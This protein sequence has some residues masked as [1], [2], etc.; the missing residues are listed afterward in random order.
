M[1]H[2]FYRQVLMA[3]PGLAAPLDPSRVGD[4][5][6]PVGGAVGIHG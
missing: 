2:A 5:L 3:G 4:G 1:R 6:E